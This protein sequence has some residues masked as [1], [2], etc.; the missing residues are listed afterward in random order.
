MALLDEAFKAQGSLL[1]SLLTILNERVYKN[2]D[3]MLRDLALSTVIVCS[4]ECPQDAASGAL[5]DRLHLRVPCNYVEIGEPLHR[6]MTLKFDFDQI[7]ITPEISLADVQEANAIAR[8][9][10]EK[11][12][13]MHETS[14]IWTVAEAK[15]LVLENQEEA[16]KLL[17]KEFL[18]KKSDKIVVC[19]EAFVPGPEQTEDPDFSF[20]PL[21]IGWELR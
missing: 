12:I 6:I 8:Q 10:L 20:Q 5:M 14:N 9:L 4:N 11:P 16:D 3:V 1:S 13:S 17:N 19:K 7:K 2:G 18:K 21:K 15:Y